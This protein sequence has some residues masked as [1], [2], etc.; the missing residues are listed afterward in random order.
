MKISGRE[1]EEG[2]L[3]T[4]EDEIGPKTKRREI[5]GKEHL[6]DYVWGDLNE[7][8]DKEYEFEGVAWS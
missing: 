2:D 4:G 7:S 3:S 8:L 5:W 6:S 1:E